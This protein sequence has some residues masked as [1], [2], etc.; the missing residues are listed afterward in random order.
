MSPIPSTVLLH[1]LS[2]TK[3]ARGIVEV[4]RC[5]CTPL[6]VH[7]PYFTSACT[8]LQVHVVYVCT[9]ACV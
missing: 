8:I 5:T 4:D 3:P 2:L 1:D 9:C 7:V 6:Q